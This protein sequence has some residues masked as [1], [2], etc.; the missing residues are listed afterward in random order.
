MVPQDRRL[1]GNTPLLGTARV[2]P[3]KHGSSA[4]PNDDL[5]FI[6]D[7]RDKKARKSGA[8]NEHAD[9]MA[10]AVNYAAEMHHGLR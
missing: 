7:E 8:S 6:Q 1:A 4:K 2:G 9:R 10:L 3:G 5:R